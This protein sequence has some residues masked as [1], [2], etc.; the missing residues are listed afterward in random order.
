[1]WGERPKNKLC[2]ITFLK[3]EGAMVQFLGFWVSRD[4]STEGKR[5][6]WRRPSLLYSCFTSVPDRTHLSHEMSNTKTSITYS[7]C[8]GDFLCTWLAIWNVLC[9]LA[10][11]RQK[12][13]YMI[14]FANLWC[15]LPMLREIIS[16]TEIFGGVRGW[17]N[18]QSATDWHDGLEHKSYRSTF[19]FSM[20]T[21]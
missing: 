4:K 13:V 12:N 11:L 7:R 3:I 10:T 5:V 2:R 9:H 18:Q 17:L 1:M 8:C 15:G 6:Q 19:P 14:R 16:G 21:L 20:F